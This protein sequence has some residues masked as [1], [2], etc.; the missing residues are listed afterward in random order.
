MGVLEPLSGADY[1]R[2]WRRLA[3]QHCLHTINHAGHVID[4]IPLQNDRAHS[5]DQRGAAPLDLIFHVP[6]KKGGFVAGL[7]HAIF[8]ST[9]NYPMQ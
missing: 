9:E 1:K 4:G 3:T 6:L 7:H 5:Q 2:P 8:F